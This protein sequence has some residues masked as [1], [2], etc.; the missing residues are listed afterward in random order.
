MHGKAIRAAFTSTLPVLTGYA[1]LGLAY[2]VVMSEAG[3]P[4]WLTL[5]ISL[6]VYAGSMQYAA[7]SVL[8][9]PFNPVGALVLTLMINARH[10]FYGISMLREYRAA[11]KWKPY[12]IFSLTD[13]TFSVNISACVPDGVPRPVFYFWVSALDQF[14][15]VSASVL[16]ALLGNLISFD[17]TGIDFVMTALFVAIVTGQWLDTKEHRPALAGLCGSLVCLALFGA[18]DFILPA[19]AVIVLVLMALRRPIEKKGAIDT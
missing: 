19:M 17:T 7:V 5:L 14:Y 11:G 15:W 18:D 13:E 10:L 8:A 2:G 1:F 4:F 12:L 9:A 6:F 3:H 16:G